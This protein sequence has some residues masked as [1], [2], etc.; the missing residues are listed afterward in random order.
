[1]T[2]HRSL[3][4]GILSTGETIEPARLGAAFRV[5]KTNWPPHTGC[6]TTLYPRPNAFMA[7][8]GEAS[9]AD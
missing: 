8:P 1:V 9:I 7:R 5:T 4:S 3:L 2:A 6:R